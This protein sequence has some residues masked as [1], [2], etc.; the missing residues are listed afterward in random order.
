MIS[1]GAKIS[2]STGTTSPLPQAVQDV[3]FHTLLVDAWDNTSL[4]DLKSLPWEA[5]LCTAEKHMAA[6]RAWQKTTTGSGGTRNAAA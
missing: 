4:N 1:T 3:L 5:M 6:Y 2:G